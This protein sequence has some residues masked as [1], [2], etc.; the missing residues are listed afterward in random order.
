MH[1]EKS[2]IFGEYPIEMRVLT[3]LKDT[4]AYGRSD[5]APINRRQLY[6]TMKSCVISQGFVPSER[7]SAKKT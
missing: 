4:M 5:W 6:S 7:A 3:N 2:R 1:A